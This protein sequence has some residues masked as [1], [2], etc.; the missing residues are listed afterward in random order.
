MAQSKE[1][2]Q[3]GMFA[4]GVAAVAVVG[5]LVYQGMGGGK[6]KK[7]KESKLNKPKIAA[8]EESK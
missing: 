3:A 8:A 5:F 4:I 7:S 6:K 1:T 2:S